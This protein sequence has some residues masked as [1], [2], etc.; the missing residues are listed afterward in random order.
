[1]G[2]KGYLEASQAA[3]MAFYQRQIQG[4]VVMLNL[5]RYR[6]IADYSKQEELA[7]ESE[8]SGE[9]AYRAYMEH[10]L[11]F[12]DEMGSEVLF[13]GRGGPWL[14]GPEAEH[15]DAVLLVKHPSANEFL[16]FAQ[17]AAYLKGAGHRTAALQDSRLLPIEA[18][19]LP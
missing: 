7:P 13:F 16:S 11:P 1:M 3:G 12:L 17:N 4:P 8:V 14:I 15:W 2:S 10:T 19:P 6:E 18:M 5:L 9:E